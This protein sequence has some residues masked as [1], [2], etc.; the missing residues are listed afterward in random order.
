[1]GRSSEQLQMLVVSHDVA[2]DI[3]GTQSGHL[4]PWAAERGIVLRTADS[5]VDVELPEPVPGEFVAVLGSAQAAYDDTQPWIARERVWIRELHAA[6]V[7]VLGICFGGQ[8]LSKALGGTV[9]RGAYSEFGWTDIQPLAGHEAL[10]GEGPWFSFHDDVFTVP[11]GATELARS[12]LCPQAFRLGRSLAVQFH[13]EFS[14]GMQPGWLKERQRQLDSRDGGVLDAESVIAQ[15]E[16][17]G[18]MAQA[19]AYRLFDGFVRTAVD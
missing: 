5:V 10:L 6:G 9:S 17:Y 3:A 11:D 1:V 19:A 18:S 2:A 14:I 12:P 16:R 7:P 4:I 8:Q 15:T 13:P